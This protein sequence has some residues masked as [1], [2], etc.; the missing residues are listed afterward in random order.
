MKLTINR[1]L[2]AT[3]FAAVASVV[4]SKTIKP[5]LQ[6]VKL[7]AS[8]K[9]ASLTATDSEVGIRY[10]LGQPTVDTGGE[11]LLPKHRT[12]EIL[13]DL[14]AEEVTLEQDGELLV[15]RGGTTE[16]K[17]AT[18][19]PAEFPAIA[20]FTATAYHIIQS[21]CL[22]TM[23]RRTLFACDIESTRYALGG[24]LLDFKG[25]SVTFAATDT[26]RLAVQEWVCSKEGD[27]KDKNKS[28]V[29][30]AR[31]MSLIE[32]TLK[33]DLGPVWI[34]V[35]DNHILVRSELATIYSRLVEG[36]FP[37]YQDV[38]PKGGTVSVNLPVGPF[39]AAVR[40]AKIVTS[41]E[42]RGV[43]FCFA[44]GLLT[45]VSQAA[46]V[47]ESKV[48][49]PIEYEGDELTITF[50]PRYLVE[51]LK[52]LDDDKPLSLQMTNGDYA[53][54]FKTEDG[55]SYVIMPLSRDL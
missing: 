18:A 46:D 20:E 54:L 51:F 29:V 41:E 32:R 50:D 5:I 37:K 13:R 49:L 4:P 25:E 26:R 1:K 45:L 2:L 16:Y 9:G 17:L 42:S 52:I 15:I 39:H 11:M 48:Q 38:I 10:E 47:G 23:I 21:D 53:A 22:R 55:Y 36:R 19:D 28:P 33:E 43:D 3:A 8:L 34:A 12:D 14:G 30:P 24:A 40:Q 7:K 6:H 35:E 44:P 31:A 27:P